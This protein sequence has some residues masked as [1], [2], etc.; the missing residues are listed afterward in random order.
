MW[1]WME[2]TRKGARVILKSEPLGFRTLLLKHYYPLR[3]FEIVFK[4]LENYLN[5]LHI[6]GCVYNIV[7]HATRLK[8]VGLA[9]LFPTLPTMSLSFT[10]RVFSSGASRRSRET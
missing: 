8:Q 2:E 10:V 3:L 7:Q 1:S 4:R 6:Q 9:S 5:R